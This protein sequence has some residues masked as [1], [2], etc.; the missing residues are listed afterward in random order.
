MK[1]EPLA[2]TLI[3]ALAFQAMFAA[4]VAWDFASDP[5]YLRAAGLMSLQFLLEL[6]TA[7]PAGMSAIWLIG[8][9][10]RRRIRPRASPLI[11]AVDTVAVLSI[12]VFLGAG[13]WFR[14]GG[15]FE[16]VD[17]LGG[18]PL[19]Q[20]IGTVAVAPALSGVV[21]LILRAVGGEGQRLGLRKAAQAAAK[22]SA[23]V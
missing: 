23:Q 4:A 3:A 7:L 2:P 16:P 15:R 10:R 11:V 12:G 8:A 14:L 13:A 20:F 5:L 6:V 1:D 18:M 19:P 17:G 21:W 22:R 9:W